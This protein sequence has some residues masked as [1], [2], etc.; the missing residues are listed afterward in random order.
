MSLPH[1]RDQ[2]RISLVVDRSP[3]L[4]RATQIGVLAGPGPHAKEHCRGSAIV[5]TISSPLAH[6]FRTT[7]GGVPGRR[8]MANIAAIWTPRLLEGRLARH[9]KR[10]LRNQMSNRQTATAASHLPK[11]TPARIAPSK[12]SSIAVHLPRGDRS[13]EALIG[14]RLR[15]CPLCVSPGV[16]RFR[17]VLPVKQGFTHSDRRLILRLPV[18][19]APSERI[20]R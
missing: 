20:T 11:L 18:I 16:G 3:W 14:L 1:R 4:S 8:L 6:D 2:R 15:I 10:Q 9:K 5:A 7:N 19:F 17:I 12:N 13:T